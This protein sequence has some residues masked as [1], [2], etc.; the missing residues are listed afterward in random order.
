MGELTMYEETIHRLLSP[1]ST[2]NRRR[3]PI[4]VTDESPEMNGWTSDDL[5][6]STN[7][8][9]AHLIQDISNDIDPSHFIVE[10]A[11]RDTGPA[12]G[13]VAAL[14]ELTIPDEPI[15]FIPSDHHIQDVGL[16]RRA[17][18]VA[19]NVIRSKGALVD[20]A[21]TPTFPNVNLGY[22]KIGRRLASEQGIELYEFAGHTEKPDH[23]T[24]RSFI[25]S[26]DYL[27][28]ANYYMWTPRKFM[29]AY[30]E[31]APAL[32][33][34]LRQIQAAHRA[35]ND[36]EV[37]DRYGRMEKISIDYAISE[38]MDPSNVWIIKG[39]FGWSD[40][41]SWD[42]VYAQLEHQHDERQNLI[43]GN[44]KGIDTT[45]TVVYGHN[46]KL[47]AT[48]GVQNLVIIDTD[49]ALLICERERT[50]DVKKIAEQ[51]QAEAAIEA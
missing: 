36:T 1:R 12:M 6:V 3:R 32:G 47:I 4:A 17:F 9:F 37:A 28:H 42:M 7:P 24:A 8:A 41:G 49:D 11:R 14:L 29:A 40:L 46:E 10:P 51:L 15:A 20:I 26:G 35:G 16:F 13:Y 19:E 45:G 27:W 23:A 31:L 44:W 48:I 21:I 18:T 33:R 2:D 34:V 30:D 22:T 5:Y 25:E 39:E 50:Q 43:R 38:K